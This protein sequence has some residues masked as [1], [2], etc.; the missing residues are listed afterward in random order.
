MLLF[1]LNLQ[2]GDI[3]E[4]PVAGG[5]DDDKRKPKKKKY[6]VNK[7]GQLLVFKNQSDAVAALN[8]VTDE[9]VAREVIEPVVKQQ[10]H[11]F[12]IHPKSDPSPSEDKEIESAQEMPKEIIDYEDD[13]I[14]F[15]LM[16][17]L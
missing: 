13:D 8:L 7:D 10:N 15:L 5:Y 14:E 3:V 17:I 11:K 16:A 9:D 1:Q 4:T 6:V 2:S 12:I